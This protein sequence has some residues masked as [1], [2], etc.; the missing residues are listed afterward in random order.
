MTAFT[1]EHIPADRPLVIV[2]TEKGGPR[3]VSHNDAAGW[4]GV[5][6]GEKLGDAR[7][8]AGPQLIVRPLD[9][10]A[11]ALALRRLALWAGRYTPSIAAWGDDNGSDGL[12]LDITGCSHLF[13]GEAALL[14]DIVA[15]L[16]RF[17]LAA[18]AAVAQTPGMAWAASHFHALTVLSSPEEECQILRA[19][20]IAALR[21]SGETRFALQRLGFKRIGALLDKARAPFAARFEKELLMRID[22]ALGHRPEALSYVTSPP[23]YEKQRQFLQPVFAQDFLISVASELLARMMPALDRDGVGARK[24]SLALYG[25]GGETLTVEIGVALPIRDC[26]Q[27]S[28]FLSLKLDSLEAATLRFGIDMMRLSVIDVERL[29]P[30]QIDFEKRSETG[31]E[32]CTRLID[33]LRH[34]L[35]AD[36]IRVLQPYES[37]L[38]ERSEVLSPYPSRNSPHPAS[39]KARPPSPSRGGQRNDSFT[40]FPSPLGGGVRGG[41]ISANDRNPPRPLLLLAQAETAE[42]TALVPDG[43]PKRFAWRGKMHC[44]I[45]AQGPE[46]ISPEWWRRDEARFSR[47]YYILESDRGHRFWLY[48]DGIQERETAAPKWFVHGFFA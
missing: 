10:E 41:G 14:A 32:R 39:P 28:R 22:Q 44:V 42:V 12:F 38:P 45:H 13:G 31:T 7:A 20:P 17:G 11:D 48:R 4:L 27:F 26:A 29:R 43:A 1:G 8:K 16:R 5:A 6:S 33:L 25:T 2:Q 15:R 36:K 18:Q 9:A 40:Y 47:D 46:R 30:Q 23:L 24:L 35:G 34:R 37:H 19:L 21:L 3:I